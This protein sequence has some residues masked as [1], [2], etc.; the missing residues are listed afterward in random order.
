MLPCLRA[1]VLRYG[2]AAHWIEVLW[3]ILW[4]DG[5]CVWCPGSHQAGRARGGLISLAERF[6]RATDGSLI[7]PSQCAELLVKCR[8]LSEPFKI[9]VVLALAF[10]ALAYCLGRRRIS[11]LEA[12]YLQQY[13]SKNPKEYCGIGGCG[14]PF[15]LAELQVGEKA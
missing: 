6:N 8:W 11:N 15:K 7:A 9:H 5:Q 14:V 12:Y 10:G 1:F 3:T 4:P 2:S 13:L